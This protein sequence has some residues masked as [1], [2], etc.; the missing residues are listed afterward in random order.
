MDEIPFTQKILQTLSLILP[1]TRFVLLLVGV[2]LFMYAI[3]G[4][5]LFC[6]LR[7]NQEIDGV[8][9]SYEDFFSALSALLKFS[10]LESPVDQLKDAMQTSQPNF[11][12]F[13]IP[14]YEEF[15]KYGQNGCGQPILAII[16]FTTF[17]FTLNMFL[18]PIFIGVIVD[19]YLDMKNLENS[20]ITRKFVSR[21]TE[22]WSK[23]DQ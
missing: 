6:F 1:R 16:F 19:G 8:N 2:W 13:E 18:M 11:V 12:C 5:E 3:V 7:H 15:E 14:S 17:N 22:E 10:I 20:E 9:Q 21:A 23:I 4:V